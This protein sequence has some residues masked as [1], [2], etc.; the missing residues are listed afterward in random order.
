MIG[1]E[2]SC[3]YHR[4]TTGNPAS[5]ERPPSPD[6]FADTLS[7]AA[8]IREQAVTESFENVQVTSTSRHRKS[9]CNPSGDGGLSSLA[10][11]L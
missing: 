3:A 5:E 7:M 9:V 6:G 11:Y 1:F 10:G 4:Q 2:S 8:A